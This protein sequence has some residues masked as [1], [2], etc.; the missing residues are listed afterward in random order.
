MIYKHTQFAYAIWAILSW[1]FGF[2]LLAIFL[3]GPITALIIF[4]AVVVLVGVLFHS[5]T[6]KVTDSEILFGFAFGWFGGRIPLQQIS[7]AKAVTNSWRHGIGMRITHDGW[8]YS[9]SGFK[10]VQITLQDGTAYRLGT[11]DQAGLISAL[12]ST[13][14]NVVE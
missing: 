14:V 12:Q 8:V 10:A 2:T 9:V 6:V 4:A 7:E 13:K 1:V 11:N 5:M 3:M